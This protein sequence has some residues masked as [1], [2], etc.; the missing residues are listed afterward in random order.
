M[1]WMQD[2]VLASDPSLAEEE[3]RSHHKELI[4]ERIQAWSKGFKKLDGVAEAQRR[5]I[6]ASPVATT[7]ELAE[8]AQLID[9]GFLREIDHPKF[10]RML[11]PIG[12]T[13]RLR[14]RMLALAPRL[15]EH[16]TDILSELGYGETEQL[17]LFE[18]GV[19]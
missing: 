9:R 3:G 8:D 10:G 16:T 13:A 19:I 15:G 5:G 7:D 18:R 1:D 4:M 17:L 12:G 6:T 11:F 14:G 2:P